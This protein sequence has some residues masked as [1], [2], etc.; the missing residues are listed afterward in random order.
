MIYSY[1]VESILF[2]AHDLKKVQYSLIYELKQ[3]FL[4]LD[5]RHNPFFFNSCSHTC[6][7]CA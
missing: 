2:L 7:C 6:G 4:F 1:L 5:F 3:V